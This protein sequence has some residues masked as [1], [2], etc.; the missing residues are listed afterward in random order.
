M[1]WN[2]KW[3]TKK[4]GWSQIREENSEGLESDWKNQV[5]NLKKLGFNQEGIDSQKEEYLKTKMANKKTE[6]LSTALQDLGLNRK[7]ILGDGNCFYY[8]ILDQLKNNGI[9][10]YSDGNQA[11]KL[12]HTSLRKI[13]VDYIKKNPE[14]YTDD[15]CAA[16]SCDRPKEL[17][18]PFKTKEEY[19][20]AHSKDKEYAD[21]SMVVALSKAIG[22]NF[23]V[24]SQEPNKDVEIIKQGKDKHTLYLYY[25]NGNH[26]ESLRPNKDN[27]NFKELD[28]LV[29]KASIDEVKTPAGKVH[30]M[31]QEAYDLSIKKNPEK[32]KD[33]T[34]QFQSKTAK[35]IEDS[36]KV[37]IGDLGKA[38]SII[39]TIAKEAGHKIDPSLKTLLAEDLQYNLHHKEDPKMLVENLYEYMKELKALPQH[40]SSSMVDNMKSSQQSGPISVPHIISTKSDK[41]R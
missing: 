7:T 1:N 26:Y 3:K 11:K 31:T 38:E 5:S 10:H 16:S 17:G 25:V 35:H 8:T 33:A 2:Q 23:V 21:Q 28:D 34:V 4:D 15:V 14:L 20:K 41:G 32:N 40:S 24:I 27:A 29:A 39:D 19:I 18:G 13:A 37:I 9:T 22:I 12:D 36:S 30:L 6:Y